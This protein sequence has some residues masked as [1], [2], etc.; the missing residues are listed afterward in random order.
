MFQPFVE[1]K[2]QYIGKLKQLKKTFL[3]TQT[4]NR[5]YD[6]FAT[7]HKINILVTD[8]DDIGLAK[9]HLAA[10]QRLNKSV[11][12]NP[13]SDKPE[14]V[15]VE[16]DGNQITLINKNRKIDNYISIIDLNREEHL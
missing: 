13:E 9:G 2:P 10:L 16:R 7:E 8:Y 3:V 6:H 4:Y 11:S 15:K 12:Q 5:A 1:F 14:E